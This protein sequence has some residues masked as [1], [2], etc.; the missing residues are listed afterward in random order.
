LTTQNSVPDRRS[1]PEP[2]LLSKLQRIGAFSEGGA[3][4]VRSFQASQGLEVDGIPGPRTRARV[5][6][7][8]ATRAWDAR[9]NGAGTG[10]LAV[11]L[12]PWVAAD[13][14]HRVD[15]RVDETGPALVT[16]GKVEAGEI[17]RSIADAARQRRARAVWVDVSAFGVDEAIGL[18]ASLRMSDALHSEQIEV[19]GLRGGA[20]GAAE[21]AI[22]SRRVTIPEEGLAEGSVIRRSGQG[23]DLDLRVRGGGESLPIRIWGK[24]LE[25]LLEAR[26][27]I[28]EMLGRVPP[29]QT[30]AE[31]AAFLRK[32]LTERY[33]LDPEAVR[34]EVRGTSF[35]ERPQPSAGSDL[36]AADRPLERG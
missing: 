10:V 35:V 5:E 9:V 17:A 13:G 27:A 32:E 34:V 25:I 28:L 14:T 15:A 1:G 11:S 18:M 30:C 19:I 2:E 29:A 36:T 16:T 24:T 33:G 26:N 23:Y 7:I 3:D 8:L 22:L 20:R 31:F 6:Q 4:A 12:E 21:Q